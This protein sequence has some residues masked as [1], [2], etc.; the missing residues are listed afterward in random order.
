M[1]HLRP[2]GVDLGTTRVRVALS[3]RTPENKTRLRAIASRDLPDTVWSEGGRS[4]EFAAMILEQLVREIEPR[5]R[6]C[7][8]ALGL[9]H[10]TLRT[11]QFPKMSW[12]ERRKAARFEMQR[13]AEGSI[14]RVHPVDRDAGLFAVAAAQAN[15]VKRHG[16]ILRKAGLR[17]VAIDHDAYALRRALPEFDAVADIGHKALRLHVFVEKS[18]ISWITDAGGSSITDGIAGDLAIDSESA[19]RRK[20]ILGTSGA[21]DAAF[22]A[23]V[24]ELCALVDR[25]AAYRKLERLALVGNG[26]RLPGFAAEIAD[27]TGLSVEFPVS[28]LLRTGGFP[29]DVLQVA[30]PDWTLAAA[31]SDWEAA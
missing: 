3:E 20:R 15:L 28:R 23:L 16:E 5:K 10:A 2:L 27:R 29:S 11:V 18:A 21:G 4:L 7:V 1:G 9:P 30:S 26:A 24:R 14:V 17:L 6:N 12:L 19:E 22:G 8:T 31:L 25:G 13:E